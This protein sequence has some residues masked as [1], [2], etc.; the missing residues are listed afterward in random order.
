MEK[1]YFERNLKRSNC[2]LSAC[3]YVFD[4]IGGLQVQNSEGEWIDVP[5]I[6]GS[7]VVNLGDMLQV[8]TF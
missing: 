6:D 7:F 3:E 4:L 2:I 8:M 5:F 1:L